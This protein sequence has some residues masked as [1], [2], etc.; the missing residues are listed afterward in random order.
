[1]EPRELIFSVNL[2]LLKKAGTY[3]TRSYVPLQMSGLGSDALSVTM[4]SGVRQ[5]DGELPTEY[6]RLDGIKPRIVELPASA[7]TVGNFT[8]NL[9]RFYSRLVRVFRRHANSAT[10]AILYETDPCNQTAFALCKLFKLPCFFWISGD[11]LRSARAGLDYSSRSAGRTLRLLA[12]YQWYAALRMLAPRADGLI[13]CGREM[14]ERLKK[15]NSNIFLIA[16]TAVRPQDIEEDL[17]DYRLARNK[18]AFDIL[19]VCRI[20][21][22]K[23]LEYLIDAVAAIRTRGFPARLWV[24]GPADVPEYIAALRS[25]TAGL[26]LTEDVNFVGRVPHGP[27][28][29]QYYRMADVFA[30]PS[31]SEGSPKV[32]PE[33]LAKGL[34]VVATQVGGL[35]DLV[36]HGQ[37]GLLVT[38]G[39]SEQLE[40][41]LSTLA[42]DP[43]LRHRMGKAAIAA[44]P[45][46]TMNA[47]FSALRD[48]LLERAANQRQRPQ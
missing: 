39:S 36:Q 17:P 15:S 41:A 46:F 4:I 37:E 24:V 31:L 12:Q 44:A 23:A 32:I 45:K 22:I 5:A 40:G 3:Y 9:P 27:E 38:P 2:G 43:S 47:Q 21:P 30:L 1:M 11:S 48:W 29:E 16:A 14:A 20:T 28:L 7:S 6:V 10:A 26:G 25:R 34:P 42:R 19:T 35:A 33:A 13:V 18:S 8:W